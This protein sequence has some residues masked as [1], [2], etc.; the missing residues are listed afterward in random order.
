MWHACHDRGSYVSPVNH[1]PYTLAAHKGTWPC[2][3]QGFRPRQG[4][5]TQGPE[6]D[7][8]LSEGRSRRKAWSWEEPFGGNAAASAGAYSVNAGKG[9]SNAAEFQRKST[10]GRSEAQECFRERR[11]WNEGRAP[12]CS[13]TLTGTQAVRPPPGL[14][15]A[16]SFDPTAG[17]RWPGPWAPAGPASHCLWLWHGL[18]SG[19]AFLGLHWKP[20]WLQVPFSW[21]LKFQTVSRWEETSLLR[22]GLPCY[23]PYW[24]LGPGSNSEAELFTATDSPFWASLLSWVSSV[25]S[26]HPGSPDFSPGPPVNRLI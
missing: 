17:V 24:S 21:S 25:V 11:F 1:V 16:L 3:C 10:S 8:V 5:G 18:D 15:S 19:L 4:R 7:A 14:V 2:P 12:W 6:G 9:T 23:P 13:W 22:A 20:G 26:N